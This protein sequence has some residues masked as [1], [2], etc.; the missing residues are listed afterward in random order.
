MTTMASDVV[1]VRGQA[2]RNGLGLQPGE[3]PALGA[4]TLP[5]TQRP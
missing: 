1:I 5:A 4:I 3:D 2:V